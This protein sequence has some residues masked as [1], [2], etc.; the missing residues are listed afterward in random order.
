MLKKNIHLPRGRMK[1]Y[2]LICVFVLSGKLQISRSSKVENYFHFVQSGVTKS[3]AC[4]LEEI[5][6]NN[7]TVSSLLQCGLHCNPLSQCVGV[8]ITGDETKLCRL[9][10]EFPALIPTY[11]TSGE[12]VRYSK[13]Y[14]LS[15]LCL[16][17]IIF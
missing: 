13:V 4:I 6:V 12:T 11:T 9:L 10:Y 16:N 8:D 5:P 7:S 17:A 15:I 1:L 2:L 3:N 14:I